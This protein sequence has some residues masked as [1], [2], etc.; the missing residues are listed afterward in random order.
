[1]NVT[2][3]AKQNLPCGFEH[4]RKTL[5]ITTKLHDIGKATRFF[6]TY[7][8][9]ADEKE[10]STL[11]NQK[12]TN[13]AKFSALVS[14]WAILASE[15]IDLLSPGFTLSGSE[16]KNAFISYIAV[17]RHHGDLV[18]PEFL[19]DEK[20]I[21][22]FQKQLQS[23][24][25]P[26][27]SEFGKALSINLDYENIHLFLGNLQEIGRKVRSYT[28]NLKNNTI[29]DLFLEL[30][31]LYSVLIDAD[32]L[33]AG[34]SCE[35]LPGRPQF[36][37]PEIVCNYKKTKEWDKATD[38][39]N[40]LRNQVYSE[41]LGNLPR[42]TK[43]GIYSLNVP[44]GLG[45]TLTSFSL[46]MKLR[47]KIHK[48]KGYYP[49][50][51]YSLPFTSI[52]EQNYSAIQDTGIKEDDSSIMLKHHHLSEV[53]YKTYED[54]YNYETSEAQLLIESWQ[55][56][57][58]ITTFVQLFH[59]LIG[60]KNRMMKKFNKIPS[61]ILILDEIQA[62]PLRYWEM[63]N[64]IFSYLTSKT[65]TYILMVTA[66]KPSMVKI[67]SELVDRPVYY[68][69]QMSRCWIKYIEESITNE[70][71]ISRIEEELDN[72][73]SVLAVLNTISSSIDL[74][75]SIPRREEV[76]YL[77]LSTNIVP[78]D[79]LE[80]IGKVK[81][82][83]LKVVVSTQMV[84]AGVDIDLDIVFRDIAPFDSI[85]QSAGRCNRN[86]KKK[87]GNVYVLNLEN[88]KYSKQ[89]YDRILIQETEK[90]LRENPEFP[91]AKF[92]ELAEDYFNRLILV[93]SQNKKYIESIYSLNYDEGDYSVK[94]FKLI[95]DTYPKSDIFVEINDEAKE[96]FSK[97][98]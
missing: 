51:I 17:Q 29:P 38:G 62:I 9:T 30:N 23:I 73:H 74:F 65:N 53:S 55:S 36:N 26:T 16:G 7:L 89:I 13:H 76:E 66:S 48:E 75:N 45:K 57:I 28:R 52:I 96:V 63:I 24:T 12:E 77:Y 85:M 72:N 61:S 97:Y 27:L 33:D 46:A 21:E 34:I 78:H 47:D 86:F 93:T 3:I 8:N 90:I 69:E 20:S 80:R 58:I 91:E 83:G 94:E 84:E 98:Q 31:W 70:D 1:M 10:R 5:D 92:L 18:K 88:G 14:F 71:L 32:K 15:G 25:E 68:F 59:S 82:D 56:E 54:E 81:K 39:I 6:Q 11:K 67:D 22:I 49:R 42:I 35:N 79:R 19:F 37:N 2:E 43:P 4:L 95:E 40:L 41:V 87:Q 64:E 44:T 60:Y 50:I